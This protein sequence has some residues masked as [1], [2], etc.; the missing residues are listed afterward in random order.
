MLKT[1]WLI[2]ACGPV[3]QRGRVPAGGDRGDS[4]IPALERDAVGLHPARQA[5][6]WLCWRREPCTKCINPMQ[7]C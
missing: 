1:A 2:K 6:A 7:S 4:T 3:S 5:V